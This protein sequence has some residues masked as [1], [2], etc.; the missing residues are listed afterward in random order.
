MSRAIRPPYVRSKQFCL[1]F[2]R[3]L[4]SFPLTCLEVPAAP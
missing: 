1:V 3:F 2:A 4:T